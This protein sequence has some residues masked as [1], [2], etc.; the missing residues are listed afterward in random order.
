MRFTL[1]ANCCAQGQTCMQTG[2]E[3]AKPHSGK[4]VSNQLNKNKAIG[5]KFLATDY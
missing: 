3:L 1:S 2:L 5:G 4:K